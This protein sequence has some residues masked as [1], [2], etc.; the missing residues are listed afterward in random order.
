MLTRLA[1][2]LMIALALALATVAGPSPEA[3][4]RPKPLPTSLAAAQA[5]LLRPDGRVEITD[6]GVRRVFQWDGERWLEVEAFPHP[7]RSPERD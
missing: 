2:A 7:E 6:G 5:F 4:R 3:P 1:I